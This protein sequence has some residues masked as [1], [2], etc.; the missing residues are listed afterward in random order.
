MARSALVHILHE[1]VYMHDSRSNILFIFFLS[2]LR[3][4]QERLLVTVFFTKLTDSKCSELS[5]WKNC[6][7][8]IAIVP[9]FVLDS[10]LHLPP[11]AYQKS[12]FFLFRPALCPLNIVLTVFEIRHTFNANRRGTRHFQV[13]HGGHVCL[14]LAQAF[15]R[16]RYSAIFSRIICPRVHQE[17]F[18]ARSKNPIEPP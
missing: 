12:F 17:P 15:Y 14:Q 8:P 7:L 16:A 6:D 18:S 3:V 5:T 1:A 4:I 9:L 11:F 13:P 10:R 2:F